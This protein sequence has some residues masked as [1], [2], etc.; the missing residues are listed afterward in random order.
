ML[1]ET[2]F[3]LLL[4]YV[5][6]GLGLLLLTSFLGL[7]RYLR[8]RQLQMPTTMAATWVG[9]GATIAIAILIVAL[10]IPR[11][12]GDYSVVDLIDRAGDEL[13][14]AAD[15]AFLND[16]GG[17]GDGQQTGPAS[18][19]AEQG[20]AESEDQQ[21]QSGGQQQGDQNGENAQDRFRSIRSAVRGRRPVLGAVPAAVAISTAATVAATGRFA[22]IRAGQNH[23]AIAERPA[24]G[25]QQDQNSSAA[26]QFKAVQ[27]ATSGHQNQSSGG[28][29][30][31]RMASSPQQQADQQRWRKKRFAGSF[32]DDGT[33]ETTCRGGVSVRLRRP[34]ARR[35]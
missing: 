5:A 34:S 15:V 24:T 19:D 12:Q 18:H 32:R 6:A 3:N 16:D 17:K 9:M 4:V 31:S 10:L 30:S 27:P 26:G 14:E 2:A 23:R 20:A 22:A 25:S 7:R 35:R 28:S 8:Q 11:P 13:Q 33:R 1:R 29:L 21:G